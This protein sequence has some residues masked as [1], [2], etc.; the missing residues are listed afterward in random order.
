MNAVPA[1]P[2]AANTKMT[3]GTI[4]PPLALGTSTNEPVNRVER[5]GCLRDF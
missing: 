3:S 2:I 5:K 1:K 4:P